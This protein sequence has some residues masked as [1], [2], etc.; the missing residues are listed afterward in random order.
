MNTS[1]EAFNTGH[2]ISLV[3]IICESV[4]SV[5]SECSESITECSESI[6]LV[7]VRERSHK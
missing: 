6:S 2:N 4:Q 3:Y 1:W 7:V 5:V